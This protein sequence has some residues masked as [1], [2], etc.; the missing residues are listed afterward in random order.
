M[1]PIA[2]KFEW[3]PR[4]LFRGLRFDGVDDEVSLGK[5]LQIM[6]AVTLVWIGKVRG[7][8][9]GDATS[10]WKNLVG[11]YNYASGGFML[12]WQKTKND[13]GKI[14]VYVVD[15]QGNDLTPAIDSSPPIGS[16]TIYAFSFDRS[17]GVLSAY[18]NNEKLGTWV[19]TG[20]IDLGDLSAISFGIQHSWGK[21]DIDVYAVIVYSRALSDS[22]IKYIYNNPHNPPQDDLVLWLSPGSIDPINGKWWDLSPYGNHGT[23]Y[24]ATVVEEEEEVEVL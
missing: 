24:G 3:R 12:F 7:V 14:V 17:S 15:S 13:N 5:A 2:P 1:K 20:L 10:F 11:Q 8:A 19:R 23:I 9:E 22:E 4:R 18:K 21:A 16:L 6:D